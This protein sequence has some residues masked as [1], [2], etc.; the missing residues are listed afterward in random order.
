MWKKQSPEDFSTP[1]RSCRYTSA[2]LEVQCKFHSVQKPKNLDCW[3]VWTLEIPRCRAA[4]LQQRRRAAS[5]A[6]SGSSQSEKSTFGCTVQHAVVRFFVSETYLASDS[7]TVEGHCVDR[8]LSGNYDPEFI[9]KYPIGS[10][11]FYIAARNWWPNQAPK[12]F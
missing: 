5:R 7:R 10:F 4:K 2:I 1:I 9:K 8:K 12:F 3:V 11:V 6:R